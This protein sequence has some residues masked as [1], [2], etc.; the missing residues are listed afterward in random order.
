MVKM[1]VG[2]VHILYRAIGESDVSVVAYATK[3][4]GL[5]INEGLSR[6]AEE[7]LSEVV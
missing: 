7:Q 6:V 5:Y 4:D 2:K 1:S 3:V